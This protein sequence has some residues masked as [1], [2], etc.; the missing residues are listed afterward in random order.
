MTNIEEK[1][2]ILYYKDDVIFLLTKSKDMYSASYY[3]TKHHETEYI[4]QMLINKFNI[5]KERN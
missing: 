3:I 1:V 5:P 4:N 2:D